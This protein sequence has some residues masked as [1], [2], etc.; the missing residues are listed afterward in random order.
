MF[1]PLAENNPAYLAQIHS[2]VELMK[3]RYPD[4]SFTLSAPPWQEDAGGGIC[5]TH[6]ANQGRFGQ[7]EVTCTLYPDN[8]NDPGSGPVLEIRTGKHTQFD[9]VNIDEVCDSESMDTL[10]TITCKRELRNLTNPGGTA[11]IRILDTGKLTFESP[12]LPRR[13]E[14]D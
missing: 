5:D 11:T 2:E 8:P 7:D 4:H 3:T 1:A 12:F 14:H 9:E 10:Q 6:P 13:P